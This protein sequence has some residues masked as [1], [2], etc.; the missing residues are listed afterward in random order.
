MWTC[1]EHGVSRVDWKSAAQLDRGGI[2]DA[3]RVLARGI[4]Q[5]ACARAALAAVFAN[6]SATMAQRRGALLALNGLLIAGGRTSELRTLMSSKPG[7]DLALWQFYLQNA[8]IGAG[9]E[10]EASAASDSIGTRYATMNPPVLWHLAGWAA[11][12]Q[13][14]P[15]LRGIVR[16]LRAKADSSGARRDA[17]IA[18]LVEPRLTLATGDTAGAIAQLRALKPSGA[19]R[20]IAWR[21]WEGLGAERLLLAELH[22]A[23]GEYQEAI[24][25]ASMLDAT[26]PVPY[27][28]YVRPSLELRLRA[29]KAAGDTELAARYSE[30]LRSLER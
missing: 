18:R 25:V 1:V 8:A 30:R 10:R 5:P 21:P 9:F 14:V 17:L 24:R 28:L 23:R 12:R 27:L 13:A 11:R 22:A 16:A 3:G 7:A 26:E 4:A 29:A 15:E 19:R 20:D 6:D 2:L